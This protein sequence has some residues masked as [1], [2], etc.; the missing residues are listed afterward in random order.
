MAMRKSG[1][2][3]SRSFDGQ[4]V[5][6]AHYLAGFRVHPPVRHGQMASRERRSIFQYTNSIHPLMEQE[7]PV[8]LACGVA[9]ATRR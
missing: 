7:C 8:K 9:E 4:A 6:A 2:V 5:L 1:I 3:C